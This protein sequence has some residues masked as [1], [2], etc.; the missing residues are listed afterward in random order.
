[1]LG[2]LRELLAVKAELENAAKALQ[3]QAAESKAVLQELQAVRGQLQAHAASA[4]EHADAVQKQ[5]QQWQEHLQELGEFRKRI[6]DELASFSVLKRDIQAQILRK[7][8]AELQ[9]DFTE[10]SKELKL[11]A[12]NWQQVK[13]ELDTAVRSLGRLN[14][15]FERLAAVAQ[16]LKKED[17]EMTSFAKQLLEMDRHKLEL[18][19]ENDHLKDL[20]ARMRRGMHR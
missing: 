10:R 6:R 7:F 19:R 5:S 20:V 17:F 14:T 15:T 1:M 9:K 2:Q 4:R 13:Q 12:D 11:S 8:E 16:N 18:Q 3:G